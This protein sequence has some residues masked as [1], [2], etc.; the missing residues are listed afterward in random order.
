MSLDTG[1]IFLRGK[2]PLLRRRAED[3]LCFWRSRGHQAYPR[4]QAYRVPGQDFHHKCCSQSLSSH[5]KQDSNCCAWWSQQSK[6]IVFPDD[7][8]T[9]S[10]SL[11][12]NKFLPLRKHPLR[13]IRPYL[14]EA[15]DSFGYPLSHLNPSQNGINGIKGWLP[16]S[17]IS[18]LCSL[19]WSK[20]YSQSLGK[21][22]SITDI[23]ESLTSK[24]IKKINRKITILHI[25]IQKRI[26]FL[27]FLQWIV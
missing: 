21:G 15:C 6:I 5:T 13:D 19:L 27:N 11:P 24:T 17:N 2:R 18:P 26:F 25:Q 20:N 23:V 3:A 4:A 22:N 12:P 16:L 1:N 7:R 10:H 14:Q 9:G 8:S